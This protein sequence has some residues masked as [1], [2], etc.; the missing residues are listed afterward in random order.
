[1]GRFGSW[2]ERWN[3]TLIRKMGP[4]QI[5][6]GHPEGVDDRSIDRP[7]PM[8]GAALSRHQVI[9]PEGQVRSSTLVCPRD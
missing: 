2:Y 3:S 4:S 9:R 7:C 1:M 6:A 5:G 8:C